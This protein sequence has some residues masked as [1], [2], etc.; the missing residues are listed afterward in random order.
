MF[1]LHPTP[2]SQRL[3]NTFLFTRYKKIVIPMS[4]VTPL[5]VDSL[6]WEGDTQYA[7]WS[8]LARRLQW[9]RIWIGG[10]KV[11]T[12]PIKAVSMAAKTHKMT[13]WRLHI[14]PQAYAQNWQRKMYMTDN[15]EGIHTLNQHTVNDRRQR[16]AHTRHTLR[17]VKNEQG[18]GRMMKV[19]CN[20]I[21]NITAS[22]CYQRKP[23]HALLTY[24][25]Q[26][27]QYDTS[28]HTVTVVVTRCHESYWLGELMKAAKV[29]YFP[30]DAYNVPEKKTARI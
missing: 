15:E 25:Q 27:Q 18:A 6:H 10:E 30:T 8:N 2:G 19:F 7:V 26:Q 29:Q 21:I 5:N 4:H 28:A 24:C 22:F 11:H 20:K 16:I 13:Y 9:I 23:R 12:K 3:K 14:R 17:S 1:T